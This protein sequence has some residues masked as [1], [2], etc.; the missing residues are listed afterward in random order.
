M[1]RR[2]VSQKVESKRRIVE[3]DDGLAQYCHRTDRAI[4]ILMLKPVMAFK[5]TRL[6]HIIDISKDWYASWPWR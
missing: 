3:Y 1:D 4:E 2:A 6:R 5:H